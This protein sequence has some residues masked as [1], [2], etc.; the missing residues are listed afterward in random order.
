MEKT[1]LC[2]RNGTRGTLQD[3]ALGFPSYLSPFFSQA[4]IFNATPCVQVCP[5]VCVCLFYCSCFFLFFF[6]SIFPIINHSGGKYNSFTVMQY[7]SHIQLIF[8]RQM[9]SISQHCAGVRC[10]SL[11]AI[12]WEP[13]IS[14]DLS[15]LDPCWRSGRIPSLITPEAMWT[16]YKLDTLWVHWLV[17]RL[18][19]SCKTQL[20][21]ECLY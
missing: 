13:C 21:C 20:K 6:I 19:V 17:N 5:F 8:T 11:K 15:L 2:M 18:P 1:G 10:I 9:P 14:S 4:L 3:S 16:S 12:M 7:L